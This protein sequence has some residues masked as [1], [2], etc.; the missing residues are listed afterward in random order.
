MAEPSL[1]LDKDPRFKS[2]LE[3]FD[4]GRPPF[5]LTFPEVKL[6]GI[7]GVGFFLDAYDLF[8]INPVATMLQYRLY[9]GNNLPT[10]LEGFLKAGANIG[11]LADSL[12]RKAVYGK[13][14]VLIIVATILS[15]STP[16]GT[17]SPNHCLIYLAMFRILLG[18]GVGGD[19][20]MSASVTSDRSNLRKRGTM[21][22][23]IF[24]NQGWGS[25]VG[26]L[27]TIIVLAIYKGAIEGRHEISKVDGVWRILVGL[28][29][30]P[31]FG[32]LY[33]RLTLPES[34][35]YNASKTLRQVP[36]SQDDVDE[37]KKEEQPKVEV[38]EVKEIIKQKAH[39]R[40]FL[41]YFSEWRHAKIL[42]GTCTCWFL[43]DIAFYGINL[44][45]NVVLQQ[46]G[47][48]GNT[49]SQWT[50]LFKIGLGNLIITALGFVPG[51]WATV[52]TIEILGRKWI[53][54]QGFLIAA[55]LLA[56]I[57]GKFHDLSKPA[58]IVCFALLQFFF[59]FG[60]NSTTYCYP[61]E[62]FPTRFRA[63]AHGMSAAAGKA[64]AIISALVFNT[65]SKKIG[66]PHVLW[67]T[68]QQQFTWSIN[69]LSLELS[70]TVFFGC[71]IAGAGMCFL[72]WESTFSNL[73]VVFT[74]LLP[75]V[76]GRDPDAIFAA[77]IEEKRI[78]TGT[79][80]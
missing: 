38:V 43:L 47:F 12:G 40:E 42:I 2:E 34:N 1:P 6:L 69:N 73:Q 23:Y 16:T 35:R 51:Y 31:A 14:L 22:A 72:A 11:Y 44:N 50:R 60:A 76:K 75:E 64:G 55:L 56:V 3:E 41:I 80:K 37:L 48:A 53:Q 67:S 10:N 5:C 24:S 21:L 4:D 65:L 8:I 49:G 7:A 30:I 13:E 26:S 74:L 68:S 61:A 52:L 39:F 29:L 57:A 66:T 45:Q 46:I 17:L 18:I 25:F 32:T 28:S 33:Q 62:V 9:G 79:R 54:I 63:S 59:N 19:Y 20:P 77:E 15:I 71:C 58:F 36:D 78:A 27:A 70:T